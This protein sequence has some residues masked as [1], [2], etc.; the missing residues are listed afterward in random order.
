MYTIPVIEFLT[1]ILVIVTSIYAYFT[2]L[3]LKANQKAVAA[4]QAQVKAVTRPYLSFELIVDGASVETCIKNAGVTTAINVLIKTTPQLRTEF[5]SNGSYTRLTDRTI[6]MIAPGREFRE[7]IGT[8]R[9]LN[10]L[11]FTA[12]ISY[13]DSA[14]NI[15]KED[16]HINFADFNLPYIGGRTTVPQELKNITESIK[17][18]KQSIDSVHLVAKN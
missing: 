1:L 3:I 5:Q 16:L 2:Y 6:T 9:K 17:A 7:Y 11:D 10:D 15:Y 13:G 18:I 12:S 8:S 4:M 14:G